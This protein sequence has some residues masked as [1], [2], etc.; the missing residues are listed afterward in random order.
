MTYKI[1][2]NAKLLRNIRILK[3]RFKNWLTSD[4]LRLKR[5][6][7]PRWGY[8]QLAKLEDTPDLAAVVRICLKRQ[9]WIRAYKS[10]G[11]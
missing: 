1:N 4:E 7:E 6:G 3:L 5:N 10:L 11:K 9:D 8:R 2:H